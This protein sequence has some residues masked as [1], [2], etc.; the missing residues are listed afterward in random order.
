MFDP[1][2]LLWT[3]GL[4]ILAAVGSALLV[5]FNQHRTW[6]DLMAALFGQK[7]STARSV[8]RGAFLWLV[9]WPFPV[10]CVLLLRQL[11]AAEAITI[12]DEFVWL[13]FG[14]PALLF[15]GLAVWLRRAE[16]TYVWPFHTAAQFY[17]ALGL[18]ISAPLTA[19]FLGGG[20]RL[21]EEEL[22]ALAFIL[23][24]TLAL[25]FYATS[26][27]MLRHRFFTYV[28]TGLSFFPV[29]LFFITYS[30]AIFGQPLTTLQYGIIWSVLSLVHLL[31]GVLLDRA[32]VRYSHGPYLGGY[33]LGTFAI[34][35]TLADQS[36]L[37]WTLGLG[38]LAA[39][40]SALLVH[41]NQHRTWDELIATLFGKK[42]STARSVARSAFLWLAAW[43]FP[44]WCVLLLRQLNAVEAITIADEFVWLGFGVPALLFLGLAVWLRRTE[45]T[46]G[47]RRTYAWPFHAAAQF[48][49]VAGLV[50]SAPLTVNF[51]NGRYHLPQEAP[52]GLAFILLQAL[53]VTFYAASAWALRRRFFAHVAAW[54]SFFP[55]TLAWIVYDPAF[56]QI[57]QP[58]FAWIWTGWAAVLLAVGFALDRERKV[59]YA[60]GPYLASY[61][62]AGVALAWSAPDRLVNVYTLAAGIGLA[63]ISHVLV[64]YG[65]HRSFDDFIGLFWRK[66]G[67]VARRAARTAFLFFAAYTF[68]V[69]LAQLLTV[70]NVP[71]AW[72]G[73]AL[74]LVAPVYVAFGLAVR[75]V[76]SEYTWPLYSAG[77]ALTAIG[78]MVTYNDLALAIYVLALDAVVYAVSAYIFRQPFWLYLSNVLVPVIALLTLH[79]NESLT[80]PW[81]SGTLMGLAFLY[82]GVGR[83]FDRRK[84]TRF[85]GKR[86]GKDLVSRFALPFYAPG[87]L[88]SA[89]ALAVASS[90]RSLAI[91][92]YSAGVVLYALSAWAFRESVFLYPAAW[93]A[94]VPYYL[95][96]TLTSLE[97]RWYGLGWLPLIVGY[98]A[99]GRFVFQKTPL[100]VKNLRTFFAAPI[101]GFHQSTLARPAMPFYLLAYGLSVSMMILSQ[102]DVLPFTMAL[103]A[104]AAVYTVSAVLFRH[105]AWLYPGLLTAHLALAAY[106]AIAPSGNL[107][108]TITLPF[109]GMTWITALLGYGLSR[110]SPVARRSSAG[111][112]VFKL[113]Q[114]ELDF[115]S[116]P[117][118]GYLVTP[119][120]AQPLF[121]FAALD[122]VI[123]QALALYSFETGIILAA[124]NA[125]LLGL[126]AML[127]LDTALTYG[128]LALF[129]LGLGYRLTWAA[130]PLAESFA[131]VGGIGFGLYLVA[132]IVERCATHLPSALH[133]L[134]IWIK[135]LTNAAVFL[136][137]VAVIVTLP[138][139]ATA[140]TPFAATL[141]FAG[142]LY[143]AIAYR[144]RHHRLGYLGMAMLQLAWAL[145][146]IDQGVDQPQWYA[147]P[148]GLYFT[149]V[150]YLERRR[151]RALF[152]TIV[153]SF[154]LAVLLV[155]SFIQSLDGAQ[156]FPYFVLLL[157]EGLLVIGW[158]ATQRLKMPFFIGL[159]ASALNVVAQVVVLVREYTVNRWF[160]ILGVGLLLVTAAAFIERQRERIIARTQEWRDALETWG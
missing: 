5:H 1:S 147:I 61:V 3:L 129:L 146:L 103:A 54:L 2:T 21:P 89:V 142:A 106:F 77:Y 82:F 9:A 36:T 112:W 29:T 155:T 59:R 70:H 57:T 67:T 109:L 92:V 30:E 52:S 116:W 74:A 127:W 105:P 102:S 26:A 63:L 22:N 156:G 64:H 125:L 160:I 91:S 117:F 154:G 38:I 85:L 110:L 4:G 138:A 134:G 56:A 152:A 72:R 108:Y 149:G 17:T 50:I 104:G 20:Y 139:V 55:Y 120:W 6:D 41:F 42:Q 137:A 131:W 114:W 113:G 16:R 124:G 121:I 97:P 48:Y 32:K 119:S 158:G 100:G 13:G 145:M 44:V 14:V 84:E 153:E 150:G 143:L 12:A 19:R 51:F 27:R 94:A 88:L 69:W 135:P 141:A 35:W 43:P 99:L 130:L 23:L 151:K 87:Y 68:P 33:A 8:V 148:A 81:V 45:R 123:W 93:L 78:A 53:A 95:G 34:V 66:P 98:I 122:L 115:G 107:K 96:M 140:T 46:S 133:I 101:G 40:W 24:Q 76:K 132:L 111:R 15:L 7:Q 25:V 65:Q 157:G 58:R 49:T 62:L 11:N 18:F 136:T 39:V 10:W 73:L 28:T 80:A 60:H 31:T 144:G 75:R 47:A 90:D 71:L 159:A 83:W 126:F 128:S 86:S 118:V 79:H 37:L